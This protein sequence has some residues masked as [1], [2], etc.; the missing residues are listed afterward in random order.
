MLSKSGILIVTPSWTDRVSSP[1][2]EGILLNSVNAGVGYGVTTELIK[3]KRCIPHEGA[4]SDRS[5]M[6]EERGDTLGGI[7]AVVEGNCSTLLPLN[8][9]ILFVLTPAI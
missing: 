5:D 8:V 2:N 9:R 4:A 3:K 6:G 1:T 7:S